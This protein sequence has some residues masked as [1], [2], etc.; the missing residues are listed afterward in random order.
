MTLNLTNAGLNVLLRALAGDRV[1]FTRVQI[2]NGEVQTAATAEALANPLLDLTI[3]EI[4]TGTTNVTLQTKFSNS[5]VE[6]GFR[7]TETGIWVRDQDDDTREVLYA[8]GYQNEATADYISA[9]GDSILETQLDFLV[10]VGEAA[11]VSAAISESLVYASAAELKAH[12]ENQK[13]PHGVTKAQVGLE[14]VP[15]VGTNDQTPTYTQAST[16]TALKSGEKLGAAMGKLARAVRSLIGHLADKVSHVTAAE[17]TA[18]DGKA[19]GSHTHGASDINSGTLGVARGGTGKGSWTANRLIYPTG[20]AVLSQ[21]PAP[22][23]DGMFLCQNKSGAPFWAEVETPAI[24][25]T[26]ET[27]TYTG[28]GKTGSSSKN[29]IT[30]QGGAPKM[31]YIKQRGTGAWGL[32]LFTAA[33]GDGFSVANDV[34]CNLTAAI[35]G[36]TVSWYYNSTESHPANQLDARGVVY[37]YVAVF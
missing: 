21:L 29:S 6:D 22:T 36:N 20:T 13:N 35:S 31:V 7:H 14:A 16:L 5:T 24:P 4:T 33:G 28:G 26:S 23:K 11:N 9:S 1:I 27:G 2:G 15:N 34:T 8:Y 3:T 37:A 30:F 18:W 10:F 19:D 25:P 12:I 17:R 32:L